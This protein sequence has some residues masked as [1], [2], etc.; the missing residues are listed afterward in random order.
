MPLRR[1]LNNNLIGAKMIKK[2]WKRAE[3]A[4]NTPLGCGSRAFESRHSDQSPLKSVDFRGL[5]FVYCGAEFEGLTDNVF[6]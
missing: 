5:F 3:K 2:H 4:K 1:V 6:P